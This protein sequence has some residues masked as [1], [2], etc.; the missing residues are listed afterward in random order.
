MKTM[1]RLALDAAT[2]PGVA[3]EAL[4]TWMANGGDRRHRRDRR[5]RRGRLDVSGA[6]SRRSRRAAAAH[7]APGSKACGV[8]ALGRPS[9]SSMP[10]SIRASTSKPSSPPRGTRRCAASTGIAIGPGC[11]GPSSNIRPGPEG[12]SGLFVVHGHTP[13]DAR[14]YASHADQIDAFRLNLDAGSGLTG[15]AK[16]AIIR[17]DRAEVV[18]ARGPTNRMLR[19]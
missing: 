14:R 19:L 5:R 6:C 1:M 12:W 2:A 15:V 18:T 8:L 10:A 4:E 16:M 9:S 13:N 7:R 11:A 17:G 3:I